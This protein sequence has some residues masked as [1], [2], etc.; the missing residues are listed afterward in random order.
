MGPNV[1]GFWIIALFTIFVDNIN[2]VDKNSCLEQYYLKLPISSNLTNGRLNSQ[3]NAYVIQPGSS[4]ATSLSKGETE[5]K[6]CFQLQVSIFVI[7][8]TF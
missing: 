5:P 7:Q 8:S 3:I 6:H 2:F 4:V 1:P